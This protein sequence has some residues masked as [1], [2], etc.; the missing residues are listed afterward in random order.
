[1]KNIKS[2]NEWSKSINDNRPTDP[3]KNYIIASMYDS[4]SGEQKAFVKKIT[5]AME[6][7]GAK[8]V[9]QTDTG[10]TFELSGHTCKAELSGNQRSIRITEPNTGAYRTA[11][12]ALD[13]KVLFKKIANLPVSKNKDGKNDK[14]S[15]V[16]KITL[17][18]NAEL[19]QAQFN[20]LTV[21]PEDTKKLADDWIT[22]W[23]PGGKN[24]KYAKLMYSNKLNKLRI[25]D[26]EE[27]YGNGIVD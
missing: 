19:T 4:V 16:E 5:A 13:L 3:K 2:I 12:A 21:E 17:K 23:K 11:F 7:L 8:K 9:S 27:F 1:M 20:A 14:P 18:D 24:Q 15:K 26:M 6:E 22:V 10:W 25:T